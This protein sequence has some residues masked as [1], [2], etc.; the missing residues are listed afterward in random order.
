MAATTLT[1]SDRV[2]VVEGMQRV[3]VNIGAHG[4][5]SSTEMQSIF[6]ELGNENGEISAQKMIQML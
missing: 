2:V 5:V 4:R 1:A 3:L 6:E